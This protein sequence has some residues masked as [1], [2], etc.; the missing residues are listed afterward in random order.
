MARQRITSKA[1]EITTLKMAW[2]AFCIDRQERGNAPATLRFYNQF[3]DMYVEYC[4]GNENVSI[5]I[6]EEQGAQLSFMQHL[7]RRGVNVQTV[8]SYLRAYR[9]FGNYCLSVGYVAN[10]RCQIKEVEPPVKDVYT[11]AELNRLL[12]KPQIKNFEEFRNYTII[13]LIL[14]TGVRSNTIL[15]IKIKDVNLEEGYINFNTTKAHKVVTLGLENKMHRLLNEYIRTWRN[16]HKDEYLF[17][18]NY[19]EQMTR[20]G[21]ASA[22][23]RYNERRDVQKSSI[24]L[25][26]H[27]FCKNWLT[28][29]GDIISLAKILTHSELEMVKRYSNLYSSDLKDKIQQHSTLSQ[30]RTRSGETIK[31]R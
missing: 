3:Y 11:T 14:S 8:N 27:T 9:A 5:S 18:N 15:N 6:L 24:H 29:G 26:R 30:M 23:K 2:T 25:L 7:E 20:S 22:I 1:Q 19:G 17:C 12:I 13:S 31:T 4:L 28:S 16:T 21:L 10:F